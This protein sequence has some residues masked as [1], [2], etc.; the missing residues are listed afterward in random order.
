ML[1]P[2]DHVARDSNTPVSKSM[3]V[4]LEPLG[5]RAKDMPALAAAEK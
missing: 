3:V 5:R 1:I 4:R 2:L